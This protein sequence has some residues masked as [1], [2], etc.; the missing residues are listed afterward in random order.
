MSDYKGADDGLG[1][2]APGAHEAER[3]QE[4]LYLRI[5]GTA[6]TMSR[7]LDGHAETAL[8]NWRNVAAVGTWTK[9]ARLSRWRLPRW[10]RFTPLSTPGSRTIGLT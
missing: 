5:V 6:E 7:I 3:F 2:W 4:D 8:S 10:R 9:I 1:E